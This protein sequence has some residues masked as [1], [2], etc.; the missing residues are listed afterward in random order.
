[1]IVALAG[2]DSRLLK[3]LLS[4]NLAVLRARSGHKICLVDADPREQAYSWSCARRFARQWPTIPGRAPASSVLAH[5]IG[6]LCPDYP[7]LLINTG[8]HDSQETLSAVIAARVVVVPVTVDQV[9]ID[10]DYALIARLNSARMFN[11]A[12]KVLFVVVT[13]GATPPAAQLAAVRLYV[14]H[15]MSATLAATVLHLHAGRQ[16][17]YGRGRCVC[18][19]ETC[20][21]ETAAEL[22]SL[23]RE[24]YVH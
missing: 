3:V 5:E 22:H 12:L 2:I 23:Y 6:A 4:V 13:D 10:R 11:P 19:A 18:D 14:A 7:D 17:G 24:I 8:N 20:D 16:H 21:P 15:V 1:M 9:D